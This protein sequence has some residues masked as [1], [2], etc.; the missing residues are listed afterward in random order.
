MKICNNS[1]A[2]IKLL[3]VDTITSTNQ[4]STTSHQKVSSAEPGPQVL[5]QLLFAE[6]LWSPPHQWK[7]TSA[8]EELS[9]RVRNFTAFSNSYD[10]AGTAPCTFSSLAFLDHHR[11]N[12]TVTTYLTCQWVFYWVLKLSTQDAVVNCADGVYCSWNIPFQF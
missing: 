9:S 11:Y 6:R 10:N 2:I 8:Q 4:P 7:G 3:W 1:L 12:D 5:L